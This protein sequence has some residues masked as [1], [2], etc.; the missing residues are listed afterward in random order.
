MA[1]IIPYLVKIFVGPVIDDKLQHLAGQMDT[2][3]K[4]IEERIDGHIDS[5]NRM[6]R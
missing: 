6:R 1:V 5:H 3:F 4:H 2:R